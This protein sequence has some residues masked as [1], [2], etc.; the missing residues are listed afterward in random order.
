MDVVGGWWVVIVLG[1]VLYLHIPNV[2]LELISGIVTCNSIIIII[3]TFMGLMLV[4][5]E[6]CL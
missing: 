4:L 6:G 5:G 3:L 1:H 2:M